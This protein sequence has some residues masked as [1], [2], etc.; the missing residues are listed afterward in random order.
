[1]SKYRYRY[2][3]RLYQQLIRHHPKQTTNN[4]RVSECVTN[5][6]ILLVDLDTPDCSK[7]MTVTASCGHALHPYIV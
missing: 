1:M 7:L 2:I 4:N 6:V 5:E 3:T